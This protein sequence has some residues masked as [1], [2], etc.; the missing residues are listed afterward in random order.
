MPGWHQSG[1][2]ARGARPEPPQGEILDPFSHKAFVPLSHLCIGT[3]VHTH[4]GC[5][6]LCRAWFDASS[7]AF[8]GSEIHFAMNRQEVFLPFEEDVW[9]KEALSSP[10]PRGAHLSDP[11]RA[12]LMSP[13]PPTPSQPCL[14][15]AGLTFLSGGWGFHT[16]HLLSRSTHWPSVLSY[17][18]YILINFKYIHTNNYVYMCYPW[19]LGIVLSHIFFGGLGQKGLLVLE[20]CTSP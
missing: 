13:P 10:G 15:R 2:S 16:S 12:P 14:T 7:T 1:P 11:Q 19:V 17:F 4:T 18:I 5:F 3:N 9:E 6:F 8:T 20:V